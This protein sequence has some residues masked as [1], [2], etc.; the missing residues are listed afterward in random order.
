MTEL[1]GS[2]IGRERECQQLSAL[3][4]E[5][6]GQALVIRGEAGLGKSSL[7]AWAVRQAEQQGHVVARAVGVEAEWALPFAG[8]HQ[9][10]YPLLR[11]SGAED[12]CPTVLDVVLGRVAGPA[13]S[14]MSLGTA[15]LDLLA[16][17]SSRK[18]VLVAI[19]DAQW[20]DGPSSEVCGFIG[21]RLT[22]G[23]VKMVVTIRC[24]SGSRFD[25]AAIPEL[26]LGPLSDSA[27]QELLDTHYPQLDPQSR[28]IVLEHA[29]GNPLALLELPRC[30]ERRDGELSLPNSVEPQWWVPL[31]RRLEQM[32]RPRLE[33]LEPSVQLE[34]LRG[35]LDGVGSLSSAGASQEMRY[36][37]RNVDEAVA[38]GLVSVEPTS[39]N[40]FFRHPL[41]RSAVVH[42]AT[43]N[44][45]RA[46]HSAL[47]RCHHN[48]VERRAG[49]LAAATV[50]P[51]E[52]VAT[53]LEA[54]ARSATLRGGAAT[55]VAWLTRAAELSEHTARR[56]RRL[57]DA[58]FV[59]GHSA[60]F[61]QALQL[62]GSSDP[63][64]GEPVLRRSHHFLIRGALSARQ[65]GIRAPAFGRGR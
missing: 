36:R 31:S 5:G 61:D 21:R 54:A 3:A 1:D 11:T 16:R 8:L 51:D 33:A 26:H 48:D 22:A 34:L 41:V 4:S 64:R 19:D 2:C 42:M 62:V 24:D 65:R 40:L 47:A 20:F 43:P 44:E 57:G 37:L 45:R 30:M 6:G 63:L 38:R 10:L 58:A 35:A 56:S 49:H 27:A 9:L 28:R 46:A 13:P 7:L 59:A 60:L 50:D 52:E 32:Y 29:E 55:A 12:E 14:L 15:V 53:E 17:V 18:P 23:A 39:G 25:T